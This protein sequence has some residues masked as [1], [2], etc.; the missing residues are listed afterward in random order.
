MIYPFRCNVWLSCLF[1]LILCTPAS[2]TSGS[3][4]K[5]GLTWGVVSHN[6]NLGIDR[7]GCYGR[8]RIDGSQ[9][10]PACDPYQGDT[11]CSQYLPILCVKTE[12]LPR[13]NYALMGKGHAMPV[14]YY[15]GWAGGHLGLTEV[16]RGSALT[17]IQV[18]NVFCVAA[19]GDGYRMAEHHDGKYVAGMNANNFYGET[20]P[21]PD[22]LSSGGWHWFAYG[23]L[24]GDSRFWVH[25]NDQPRGNCW[26]A[27]EDVATSRDDDATPAIPKMTETVMPDKLIDNVNQKKRAD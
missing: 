9:D 26:E 13:P 11:P 7:V 19:L 27:I 20:W 10:G 3:D 4:V 1:I 17:S 14:E 6:N 25:I 2:W 15:N 12:G 21:S 23:N 5:S 16:I 18:A 8:P 22:Q 24:P